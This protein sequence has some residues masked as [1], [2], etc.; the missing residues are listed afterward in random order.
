MKLTAF[1]P[2]LVLV[3]SQLVGEW[4]S[5]QFRA[6]VPGSVVGAMLLFVALCIIPGLYAKIAPFAH[7]LLRN[8]LLFYVPASVGILAIFGDVARSGPFLILLTVISTWT[9]ALVAAFLFDALSR[10]NKES[11]S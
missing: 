9:T 1:F 8:M 4:I 5:V 2:F 10:N 11:A 6:P 7:T 3:T